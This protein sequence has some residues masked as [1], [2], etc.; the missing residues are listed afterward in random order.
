MKLYVLTRCQEKE[1]V[2]V[3]LSLMGAQ[4]KMRELESNDRDED[5]WIYEVEAGE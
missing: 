5:Y 1:F 4:I 2:G 3:F